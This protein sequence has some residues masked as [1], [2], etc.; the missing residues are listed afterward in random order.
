MTE[1]PMP[2]FSLEILYQQQWRDIRSHR[3]Q[4]LQAADIKI[5]QLEDAGQSATDWRNYRQQLR[6]LPQ[7]AENPNQI[8]WPSKPN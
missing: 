6:D 1:Q 3:N 8:Q 7:S 5:N 4:L 2:E